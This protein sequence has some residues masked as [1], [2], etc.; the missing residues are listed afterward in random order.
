MCRPV[1]H[2]TAHWST[3]IFRKSVKRTFW[4]HL[5]NC[6]RTKMK[7]LNEGWSTSSEGWTGITKPIA[8]VN[9]AV[10]LSSTIWWGGTG[11]DCILSPGNR[12]IDLPTWK[13]CC[14]C[15]AANRSPTAGKILL[16]SWMITSAPF[17]AKCAMK[18]RCSTSDTLRRAPHTSRSGNQNWLIG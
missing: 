9:L 16:F 11:G 17:R 13:E 5:N 4:A 3:I 6:T 7:C 12:Q 2:G 18:M 10:K 14:T 8:P 15:S 1:I